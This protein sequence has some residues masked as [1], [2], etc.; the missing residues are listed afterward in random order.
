MGNNNTM[1][2]SGAANTSRVSRIGNPGA[3]GLFSFASTI[4]IWSL[5]NV[6][7]RGVNTP[8]VIVG[9]AIFTG[10]LAMILAGMWEFPR[11]NHFG[12]TMF[13][14]YGAFWISYA[15]ILIPASGIFSAYN[16]SKEFGNALGIYFAT[17]FIFSMLMLF[18]ALRKNFTFIA[19]FFTV[20]MSFLFVSINQF[21]GN[22]HTHKAGGAFGII[23]AFIAYYAGLSELMTRE[24]SY[25]MLPLGAIPARNTGGTTTGGATSR[26]T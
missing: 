21:T 22:R 15:T 24:H 3:L 11:G 20:A 17:W 8:N 19:F 25:V 4:F 5:Y 9:M 18:G 7:T 23:A 1:G 13:T 10:G 26:R 2:N 14:S 6:N 16:N 12:A